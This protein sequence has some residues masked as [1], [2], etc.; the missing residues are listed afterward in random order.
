[1]KTT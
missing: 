1:V